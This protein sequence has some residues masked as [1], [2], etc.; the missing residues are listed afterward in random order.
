MCSPGFK[1]FDIR[2]YF[3]NFLTLP[4]RNY[5]NAIDELNNS[6]KKNRKLT[7]DSNRLF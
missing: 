7:I 6:R 1:I 5:K 2:W 4:E 3:N